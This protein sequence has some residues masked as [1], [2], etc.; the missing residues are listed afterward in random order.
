MERLLNES[1]GPTA[2]V[3]ANNRASLAFVKATYKSPSGV[4]FIGFDD[5]E[6]A[7][8]FGISVVGFDITE[9]GRQA[10][11][12]AESRVLG[13]RGTPSHIEI[14]THVIKRGSGERLPA[15]IS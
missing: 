8:T 4:A 12:L 3:A 13:P 7:D 5:F 15:D 10:A 11:R 2:I 14:P 9:M 1:D 6:L